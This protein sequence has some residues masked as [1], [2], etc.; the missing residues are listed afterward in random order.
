MLGEG[1]RSEPADNWIQYLLLSVTS[2]FYTFLLVCI[3]VH[4]AICKTAQQTENNCKQV[5]DSHTVFIE[6][7]YVGTKNGQLYPICNHVQPMAKQKT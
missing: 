2:L 7:L 4:E 5:I 1:C 3:N 6:I